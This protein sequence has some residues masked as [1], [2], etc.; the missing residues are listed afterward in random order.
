MANLQT[1]NLIRQSAL[2]KL[3]VTLAAYMVYQT[4]N[5][6]IIRMSTS[7]NQGDNAVLYQQELGS[8][9]CMKYKQKLGVNRSL[10]GI[11]W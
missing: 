11:T 8:F 1:S 3:S 10:Y 9:L 4:N 6:L 5:G 7:N 2:P